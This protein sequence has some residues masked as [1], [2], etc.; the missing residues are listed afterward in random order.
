MNIADLIEKLKKEDQT[1]EIE[2]IIVGTDDEAIV[3]K[4]ENMAKSMMK[5]LKLMAR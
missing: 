3:I 2:C 4:L 1:K 5:L